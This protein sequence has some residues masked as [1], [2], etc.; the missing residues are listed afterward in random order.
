MGFFDRFRKAPAPP[1]PPS[2]AEFTELF[3]SA[4]RAAGDTRTWCVELEHDRLVQTELADGVQPG[5]INLSNMYRDYSNAAPQDREAS[6][7]RM[8]AGM[9]HQDLPATLAEARAKLRPVIRSATE[10]GVL[11]LQT[12]GHAKRPDIAFR[13]LCG[14]LEIGIACDSEF[15]VMR[16]GDAQL[17]KWGVSFD[18]ALAIAI[19]NLREASSQPW[20]ALQNGV[21]LSQFGDFYDASRLLLTDL[22]YRQAIS[23]APVVMAP[24]RTVLLLTGDR[25]EA[26]LQTLVELAEQAYTQSRPLPPLML[27]WNGDAWE[28]FVPPALA[29]RLHRMRLREQDA[30]Y[31]DQKGLLDELHVR[32]GR[33]VFVAKHTVLQSADGAQRSVCAWSEGV[34]ALLPDTDFFVLVRDATKQTAFVPRAVVMERF[35]AH[36]KPTP[37]VPVRHE[38]VG[39]PDE[40]EFEEMLASYEKLPS[41][42]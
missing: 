31:Q 42:G 23:G 22:L 8:A 15:N 26:G 10:R 28:R 6:L 35:A 17:A 24:N 41:G 32:E 21:F 25:S 36:L 33:D 7:R 9:M 5:I 14:N 4:L 12:H 20:L 3:L 18:E 29:A 11:D 13:A 40:A 39:F 2:V 34:H 38:V 19:D 37:Y 16:L 27:R 30:D 1:A